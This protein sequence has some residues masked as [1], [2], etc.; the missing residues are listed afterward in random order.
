MEETN[1]DYVKYLKTFKAKKHVLDLYYLI[2]EQK[3]KKGKVSKAAEGKELQDEI[4]KLTTRLKNAKEMM[5]DGEMDKRVVEEL[6]PE[7]QKMKR[8]QLSSNSFEDDYQLYF[9]R[10]FAF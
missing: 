5:L 2:M 7:I 10:G 6:E 3:F 8:A 4:D 9:K 1:K